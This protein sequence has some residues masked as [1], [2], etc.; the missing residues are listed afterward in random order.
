MKPPTSH[1]LAFTWL[2]SFPECQSP[3]CLQ[4]LVRPVS[5]LGP[6]Q[7]FT[8]LLPNAHSPIH[9]CFLLWGKYLLS[10]YYEPGTV[11]GPGDLVDS[12]VPGRVGVERETK[13][14][15]KHITLNALIAPKEAFPW[16]LAQQEATNSCKQGLLG[17]DLSLTTSRKQAGWGLGVEAW[18][19]E[20]GWERRQR[21]ESRWERQAPAPLLSEDAH[22]PMNL[23]AHRWEVITAQKL[24]A[25]MSL[26]SFTLWLV[27]LLY[28]CIA[29]RV[30]F[31]ILNNQEPLGAG[32]SEETMT[33][34]LAQPLLLGSMLTLAWWDKGRPQ[35]N[36]P[37]G[38]RT[39]EDLG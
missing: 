7:A 38:G 10:S 8:D 20:K 30:I 15:N 17:P 22:L 19:Q 5:N 24:L 35:E 2:S 37:G 6:F 26:Q 25:L 33:L 34:G 36:G 3:L 16:P 39:H 18:G 29:S 27:S 4:I 21:E 1:L 28:V 32:Q 13:N 14:S 23:A 12:E 9:S 11:L 31:K